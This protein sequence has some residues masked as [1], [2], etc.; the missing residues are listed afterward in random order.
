MTHFGILCPAAIGHLNP[1]CVLGRELQRRGHHVTLFGI[2]DIQPKVRNSGLDFRTVGEAAF[3]I[4]AL[5]QKYKQLG[6]MSGLAGLYFTV[7]WLQQETVM[8]FREAPDALKA[9][10]VDALLVDQVR[11]CL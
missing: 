7:D 2:P 4:G 1:M 9:E 3:P 10:G 11:G 5:E 6:E 8:L